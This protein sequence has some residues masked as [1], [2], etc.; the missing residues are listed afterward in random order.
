MHEG[1]PRQTSPPH[2][3]RRRKDPGSEARG[4][5]Q[6]NWR[7]RW[8]LEREARGMG[9][10]PVVTPALLSPRPRPRPRTYFHKP[11]IVIVRP[12]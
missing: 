12:L 3:W 5:G 9:Q 11:L 6:P 10:H 4:M 7:R 1:T 2:F 8:T